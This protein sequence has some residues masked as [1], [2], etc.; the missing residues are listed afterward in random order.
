MMLLYDA[1]RNRVVM[2]PEQRLCFSVADMTVH[3]HESDCRTRMSAMQL[4]VMSQRVVT[5]L[6]CAMLYPQGRTR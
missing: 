5:N 4:E 1:N 6:F 2:H 3:L